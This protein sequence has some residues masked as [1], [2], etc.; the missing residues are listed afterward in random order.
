M[1]VT[2]RPGHYRIRDRRSIEINGNDEI[3]SAIIRCDG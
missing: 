1:P 2:D 3:I